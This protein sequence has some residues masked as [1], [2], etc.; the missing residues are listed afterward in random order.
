MSKITA[1]SKIYI[2]T[3]IFIYFIERVDPFY[4]R[5]RGLFTSIS[6]IGATLYTSE[7]TIAECLHKPYRI[8]DSQLV[9]I[10]EYLF[11]KSGDVTLLALNGI[12]A[13]RA[14]TLGAPLGLRLVDAIHYISALEAGCDFFV[15]TDVKFKSTEA[16][17]IMTL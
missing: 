3:N 17:T 12:V 6:T 5:A 16:M 2:D 1:S 13:K 15:S 10:Y 8:G 7:I 9:E 4:D 11:E 14:V